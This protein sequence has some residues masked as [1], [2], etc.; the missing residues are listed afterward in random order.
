[1]KV[2]YIVADNDKY[3]RIS[4]YE[5]DSEGLPSF[6]NSNST[7]VIDSYKVELTKPE[8]GSYLSDISLDLL[9]NFDIDNYIV[10]AQKEI[11]TI[12]ALFGANAYKSSFKISDNATIDNFTAIIESTSYI[13]SY[14][15]ANLIDKCI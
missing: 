7:I 8:Y 9:D 6:Y 14:G 5:Y 1:M 2:T 12:T 15:I 3:Y 13:E 4:E 11:D 10:G